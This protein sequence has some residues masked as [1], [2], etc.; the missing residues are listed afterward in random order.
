V[1]DEAGGMKISILA[2]SLALPREDVGN[3]D[4]FEVTYPY[5]LDQ[6]LRR[7]FGSQAPV[8]MERGM[9]RRTIEY[10]LDDWNE[11]VELKSPEVVIV[12]VGVVDCAPRVFLRREHTFVSRIRFTPLREGI[13]RFAHNHRRTIILKRPRV[14]VPL[15]RFEKHVVEV[16][17]RAQR[18]NV[19]L[20]VFINIISPPDSVEERSP[21]FQRN[22][23]LYNQVLSKQTE[24]AHVAL[25]DLNAILNRE[26]GSQSLTVDG[27]HLNEQGHQLIA[28]ELEKLV[29]P[30]VEE[31]A[32][33][34]TE[35]IGT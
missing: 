33:S 22:V 4:K 31:P 10:V 17:Q 9:R 35:K 5:L 12:H 15:W 24:H 7:R 16:V 13:L 3:H 26:G 20:L 11:Q 1:E 32:V 14:Y 2:D 21:G 30:L 18:D 8:V 28:Q 23:I 27:I 34:S 29:T 6:S 25:L 19:R